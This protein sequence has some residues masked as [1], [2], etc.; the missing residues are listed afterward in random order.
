MQLKNFQFGGCV[1]LNYRLPNGFGNKIINEILGAD[2]R[3]KN[4]ERINKGEWGINWW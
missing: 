4:D 3:G 2:G 1:K